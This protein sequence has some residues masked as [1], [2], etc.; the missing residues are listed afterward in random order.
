MNDVLAVSPRSVGLRE[1]DAAP[2]N[3]HGHV[4]VRR[5][6]SVR[7]TSSI[8]IIWP[9]DAPGTV[10]RVDGRARDLIT[11]HSGEPS[12][13]A[14]DVLSADIEPDRT[15]SRIESLPSRPGIEG[16]VGARGGGHLRE[17]L[18]SVLPAE[19][20]AGSPL[21]LLI[22]DL[23]GSS[24]VAMWG[25]SQWVDLWE[26]GKLRAVEGKDWSRPVMEGVCIGFRPGASSLNDDGTPRISLN[27]TPVVDLPL[28]GDPYSWHALPDNRGVAFRRARHIDVWRDD[29]LRVEAGFQDSAN[30][31]D[32]GRVAIHEY[33][34]TASVDPNTFELLSVAASPGTLP[35]S[36]CPAATLNIDRLAGTP[37][38]ELR[39]AVLEQLARTAGC[40][41][42][43][44]ALRA[45]AEVPVLA[46]LLK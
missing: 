9:Q 21:Y 10:M 12:V 37:I 44:D 41:H 34:L 15:I 31:P 5:P 24:L 42:L 7:R 43:N 35:Y 3:P 8:D 19:K 33:R 30:H 36:S 23:A 2:R 4:P 22:D 13:A 11:P 17:A 25:W 29:L 1:P 39:T 28:P 45:L 26:D 27:A 14:E 16:L 18:N 6:G 40:T 20:S 38:G 32:G 46:G